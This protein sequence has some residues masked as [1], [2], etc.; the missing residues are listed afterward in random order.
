MRLGSIAAAFLLAVTSMAASPS[1]GRDDPLAAARA[2]L[3]AGDFLSVLEAVEQARGARPADAADVLT[4]AGQLAFDQGDRWMASRYCSRALEQVRAS[5]PALELCLRAAL[6]D[7]RFEEARGH[8]DAL[9][10]LLPADGKVALLRARTA[11]G[12][13]Q[14]P[15]AKALLAPHV[16]GP[17]AAEVRALL[18]QADELVLRLEEEKARQKALE[19]S[20][21]ASMGKGRVQ[22]RGA[23]RWSRSSSEVVLYVTSWCGACKRAKTWLKQQKVEHVVRDLESDPEASDD[24]ARKC[25]QAGIR[26]SGVPVLDARGELIVGFGGDTYQAALRR[27]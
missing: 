4:R 2:S 5:G 15:R 25:A 27:R 10:R 24:L 1:A 12:E 11:L 20:L 21:A 18:A 6:A 19:A 22:R 9:A 13:D 26:P 14:P 23:A 7:E 8:G 3:A 17:L 16:S